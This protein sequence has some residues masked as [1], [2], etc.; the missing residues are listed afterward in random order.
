[1]MSQRLE[2]LINLAIK[3]ANQLRHEYLT[4]EEMFWA[5]L[6]DE[7]VAKVITECGAN[8]ALI[9]DELH[10]F[11]TNKNNFSVLDE[12]QIDELGRKQ[13][14][15]EQ[16]RNLARENGVFYQ[17]EISVGL[18]RVIQRAALHV[19]SSG[20]SEIRGINILVAMFQESESFA[21]YLL[22][23]F[24][25]DRIKLVEIIAHGADKPNNHLS[26]YQAPGVPMNPEE[27]GQGPSDQG[28]GNGSTKQKKKTALD[29][30]AIN[31]NLKAIDGDIDPLIGRE[32]E[33]KR[34]SQVLCRRR[35]N[36]P[37]LV[38][39]AGVGKTAIAEG[40]ALAIVNGDVP[41]ILHN[42]VVYSLDLAGLLAGARFRGDFEERLKA[43]LKDLEQKAKD[44]ETPILFI[45][46]IHTLMG[47]GSTSGSNMDAANLLK[48]HLS[49]KLRCLGSTTHEEFR[50]FIEKDQAFGRRFQKVDVPEP[51]VDDTYKI[52]VGLK[53]KFEEHHKVKFPPAVLKAAAKLSHQ[54]LADRKLP[55]KAIDVIDE[56]GAMM[57]ILPE[58]KRRQTITV[59]DIEE[60]VA[61][62]ARIPKKSVDTDEKDKLRTLNADLKRLIFGQDQ[63]VDKVSEAVLLARSGLGNSEKP[64]ASFMFAGPTG[65]GKTE[66]AKQLALSLGIH[67][68][69]FDMS[70]YMEKHA[71]SKLIGAPPGYVGYEDG[72]Q[73]T[74][75]VKKQPHAVLLLDEIEK[76][77][78]DI[79]NILL[80]VMDHGKLTDAQGRTTDFRNII[81][82]MT[83]NAGARDMDTGAIGFN[84]NGDINNENKRDQVI[85]NFFAPE[86]RNRMDAIV[87]FNRLND[88]NILNIVQKF[89]FGLENKLMEKKV[90][91]EVTTNAKE[92]LARVGFDQKM[93]AR[94]I[95]RAIDERIKKPLAQEILFGKL[96]KGGKVFVDVKDDQVIFEYR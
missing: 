34:I 41:D 72:G 50:K 71:V 73:L 39:E 4:L 3:K 10:T 66:L 76:A 46:E 13:F 32:E 21:I 54:H 19:Q 18:Q 89:L 78:P 9:Q 64:T 63:A 27:E 74:D 2:Y 49:G 7:N 48:P 80:Q 43:V 11:L 26:P 42:A 35:K 67:F 58:N 14:L 90:E 68:A 25:V 37:L 84:L 12:S 95:S 85:K 87:Q 5:L 28:T 20:K 22:K 24:G 6:Q 29:A 31:L 55:D 92:W 62:L 23:K 30:F 69:R 36:N 83:T 1:M 94:P 86:F 61:T 88:Q 75:V 91:L 15:D 47:A 70:E 59:K 52:L 93:G 56:A 53:D 17:P 60:V 96:Q 40:L 81:L 38:G 45:D 8:V 16:L 65:V 77:H 33:L 51:S 82:I 57:Q 44:G 79:F